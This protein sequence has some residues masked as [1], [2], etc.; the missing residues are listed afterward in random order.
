MEQMA[1][2]A[3]LVHRANEGQPDRQARR[4]LKDLRG[5]RVLKDLGVKLVPLEPLVK[6]GNKDCKAFPDIQAQLER[7]ATKELQAHQDC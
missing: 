4:E 7:K 3:N 6:K 5:Q 2:K 1:R